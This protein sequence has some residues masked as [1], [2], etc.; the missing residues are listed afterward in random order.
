MPRGCV[1]AHDGQFE[2]TRYSCCCNTKSGVYYYTTYDNR[3]IRR[4][5]M[6]AVDLNAATLYS[7]PME[8]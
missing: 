2:Y 5:D 6:H 8:E 7:Y 1:L 4:V 3:E